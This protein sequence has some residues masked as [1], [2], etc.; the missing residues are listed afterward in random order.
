[1]SDLR[2]QLAPTP[3]TRQGP[4][5][6][7]VA[8]PTATKLEAVNNCIDR[9][10]SAICGAYQLE[11]NLTG[12]L[13]SDCP[14][15]TVMES[16]KDMLMCLPGILVSYSTELSGITSRLE[17]MFFGEREGAPR[18]DTCSTP[19]SFSRVDVKALFTEQ[20]TE[21][22]PLGC[23]SLD[24][25]FIIE[26]GLDLLGAAV[27]EF[28]GLVCKVIG[29][30]RESD[31]AGGQAA[32]VLGTLLGSIPTIVD[33]YSASLIGLVSLLNQALIEG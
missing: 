15:H 27:E 30:D 28:D 6:M 2:K 24:N 8:P 4:S 10:Y 1:M 9:F 31:K 17:S 21:E 18:V 26:T 23:R 22:G 33:E 3:P 19:N 12:L 20:A 25:V 5:M 13:P 32:Y 16:V 14:G 7:G 29:T 11:A